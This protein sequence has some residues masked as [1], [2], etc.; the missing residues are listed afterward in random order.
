VKTLK[1]ATPYIA[2]YMI[3]RKDDKIA[4]L[5]RENVE[6]MAGFYG[7][8]QGKVEEGEPF[9]LAA[10]RELKEELGIDVDLKDIKHLLTN[11]R[12]EP[13]DYAN[14]WVDVFFEI[15][16]WRGEPRNAEVHKHSK[17]DWFSMD[18]LPENIIPSL[19]FS[20]EEIQDGKAYTEYGWS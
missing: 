9:T 16:K 11:H 2:C 3:V 5:L 13:S 7:L 18:E 17:L 12:N 15:T 10:Q 20:L 4:F 8:P 19:K 14:R 6:W 1:A